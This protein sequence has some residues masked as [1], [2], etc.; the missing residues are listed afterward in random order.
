MII[1]FM[2]EKMY[3]KSSTFLSLDGFDCE[4]SLMNF[5][6]YPLAIPFQN[7]SSQ[8]QSITIVIQLTVE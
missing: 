1:N 5:F 6:N 8:P 2:N 4:K 3:E 7:N